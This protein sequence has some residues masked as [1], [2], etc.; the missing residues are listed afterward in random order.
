MRATHTGGIVPRASSNRQLKTRDETRPRPLR[1]LLIA[2]LR[3]L[4]RA[5][6]TY[7]PL[8]KPASLLM[9]CCFAFLAPDM[10]KSPLYNLKEY[11]G[12]GGILFTLLWQLQFLCNRF[13]NETGTSDNRST[14]ALLFGFSISRRVMLFGKNLALLL[15]LLL[16][17]APMLAVLALVADAPGQIPN[18]LLWLPMILLTL[19]TLGNLVTARFPFPIA[20]TARNLGQEPPDFLRSGSIYLSSWQRS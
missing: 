20:H 3:L 15:L 2:G 4:L 9:L 19:T 13:G 12:I 6:Q 11:L 10:S 7:L 1:A 16:L 18:L 5:P 8:R 14:V 17:D